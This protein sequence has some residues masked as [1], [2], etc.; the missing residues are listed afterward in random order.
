LPLLV[1]NSHHHYD[2]RGGNAELAPHAVDIGERFR[3]FVRLDYATF[4]TL[5]SAEMVR[6]L[7]DLSHRRI[8]ALPPTRSL[9]DGELLELGGRRL[10]VMHAPGHSRPFGNPVPRHDFDGFAIFSPVEAT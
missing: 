3:E 7:P 4:F 1:V 6:E 5:T 10:T 9:E 8:P 2:H